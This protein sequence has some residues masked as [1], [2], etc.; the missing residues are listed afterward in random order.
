MPEEVFEEKIKVTKEVEALEQEAEDDVVANNI[1]RAE[2]EIYIEGIGH[3]VFKFPG[4]KLSLEG[5]A[6]YAK[7]LASNLRTGK[8]LTK[9]QLK[10]IY[11]QPVVVEVEGKQITVG[12]GEWTEK[13]ERELEELP[14]DIKVLNENFDILREEIQNREL[15]ISKLDGH[16]KKKKAGLEKKLKIDL[17]QAEIMYKDLAL[18]NLELIDLQTKQLT[19]FS[20]CLEEQASM[21]KV[22]LYAPSCILNKETMEPLWSSLAEFENAEGNAIRILSLFLRGGNISFLEDSQ[23]ETKT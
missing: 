9:A 4:V 1:R 3:L 18:L 7:F 14:E 23:E 19:L 6:V 10:A 20:P 11:G 22:K 21:E 12:E 5:D 17:D 8:I 2:Q 13:Q 15:E 16:S